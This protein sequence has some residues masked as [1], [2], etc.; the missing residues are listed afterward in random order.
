[1]RRIREGKKEFGLKNR[2]K[3]R[4]E[5][6]EEHR[7]EHRQELRQGYGL[8]HRYEHRQEHRQECLCYVGREKFG[9]SALPRRG[10]NS[11]AVQGVAILRWWP[12]ATRPIFV[13]SRLASR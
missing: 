7:Q 8:E 11:C 13:C 12:K 9:L 10:Y 2:Q 1:V 3:Q 6:R 5:H 4:L